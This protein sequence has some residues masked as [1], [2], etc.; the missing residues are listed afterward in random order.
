M[1]MLWDFVFNAMAFM[2]FQVCLKCHTW[3]FLD[4]CVSDK[5]KPEQTCISVWHGKFP[6][7]ITLFLTHMLLPAT[8][9]KWLLLF[10]LVCACVWHH[11]GWNAKVLLCIMCVCSYSVYVP[12]DREHD[13]RGLLHVF[14]WAA[15][16]YVGSSCSA[17]PGTRAAENIPAGL[18]LRHNRNRH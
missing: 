2:Q 13:F 14:H 6:T 18:L 12:S 15:S 1:L 17:V 5:I 7:H 16:E 4:M 11:E 10:I 9:F 8:L 3:H